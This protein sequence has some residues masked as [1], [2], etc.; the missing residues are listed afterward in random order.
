MCCRAHDQPEGPAHTDFYVSVVMVQQEIEQ[1]LTRAS[2]PGTNVII[3]F[4]PHLM[5][6]S[7]SD[8]THRYRPPLSEPDRRPG[9]AHN[10]AVLRIAVAGGVEA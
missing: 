9:R 7:R 5:P 1:G 3:N 10:P 2:P 6:M 4:T 8:H